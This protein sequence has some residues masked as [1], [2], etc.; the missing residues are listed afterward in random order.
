MQ[1]TNN[2]RERIAFK[3]NIKVY[4]ETLKALTGYEVNPKD[5]C[6]LSELDEAKKYAEKLREM[7]MLSYEFDRNG[8]PGRDFTNFLNDLNK[9]N[10]S[11]V[12]VWM[13]YSNFCGLY[14]LNSLFEFKFDKVYESVSDG[15]VVLMSDDYKDRLLI[16]ADEL[17]V[18]IELKGENW[19]NVRTN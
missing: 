14:K 15:V 10:P 3:K 13:S 5:L 11:H 2:S 17:S 9:S 16:D 8:F 18:T 6:S 4:L 7:P 19:I 1:K 12:Y